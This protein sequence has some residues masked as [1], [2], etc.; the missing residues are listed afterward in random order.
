MNNP[1]GNANDSGGFLPPPPRHTFRDPQASFYAP[2]GTGRAHNNARRGNGGRE[3]PVN[4]DFTTSNPN[5]G[6]GTQHQ[7]RGEVGRTQQYRNYGNGGGRNG[8]GRGGGRNNNRGRGGGRKGGRGN[9]PQGGRTSN[10]YQPLYMQQDGPQGHRTNNPYQ[11][12]QRQPEEAHQNMGNSKDDGTVNFFTTG[13]PHTEPP[14]PKW[15]ILYAAKQ[16][17]NKARGREIPAE[18]E[19]RVLGHDHPIRGRDRRLCYLL[20]G[21]ARMKTFFPYHL[22]FSAMEMVRRLRHLSPEAITDIINDERMENQQELFLERVQAR[23]GKNIDGTLLQESV[24]SLQSMISYEHIHA[25]QTSTSVTETRR[26]HAAILADYSETMFNEAN[27]NHIMTAFQKETVDAQFNIL[28]EAGGIKRLVEA[29]CPSVRL[30]PLDTMPFDIH[31]VSILFP[32]GVEEKIEAQKQRNYEARRNQQNTNTQQ[33][34]DTAGQWPNDKYNHTYQQTAPAGFNYGSQGQ[35]G[36]MS[37]GNALQPSD[38]RDRNQG[39]IEEEEKSRS[40]DDTPADGKEKKIS[41]L[42]TQLGTEISQALDSIYGQHAEAILN[43][44]MKKSMAELS[45]LYEDQAMLERAAEEAL[46]QIN[47][48]GKEPPE[49]EQPTNLQKKDNAVEYEGSSEDPSEEDEEETQSNHGEGAEDMDPDNM[50]NMSQELE[51]AIIAPATTFY[52]KTGLNADQ[53]L[54]LSESELEDKLREVVRTHLVDNYKAEHFEQI[55]HSFMSLTTRQKSDLIFRQGAFSNWVSKMG[56]ISTEERQAKATQRS[57]NCESQQWGTGAHASDQET[58]FD[59][60]LTRY[61]NI[62]IRQKDERAQYIEMAML[63]KGITDG[64][65]HTLRFIPPRMES[66]APQLST[67]SDLPENIGEYICNVATPTATSTMQTMEARVISS[68]DISWLRLENRICP[69]ATHRTGSYFRKHQIRFDVIAREMCSSAPAVAI[70]GTN[71]ID[72]ADQIMSEVRTR[73]LYTSGKEIPA[74]S[75]TIRW[76]TWRS[77]REYSKLEVQ[78]M[79]I[80][81]YWPLRQEMRD[82]FGTLQPN[83]KLKDEFPLTYNMTFFPF[84]PDEGSHFGIEEMDQAIRLQQAHIA[85]RQLII[86][87]GIPKGFDLNYYAR[88]GNDNDVPRSPLAELLHGDRPYSHV[89]EENIG[90]IERIGPLA[91]G[92]YYLQCKRSKADETLALCNNL[93]P[94]LKY[95]CH[96]NLDFHNVSC[97]FFDQCPP[98][99]RTLLARGQQSLAEHLNHPKEAEVTTE[100]TSQRTPGTSSTLTESFVESALIPALKEMHVATEKTITTALKQLSTELAQQIGSKSRPDDLSDQE[101]EFSPSPQHSPQQAG[102]DPPTERTAINEEDH[103][104]RSLYREFENEEG[105]P[106]NEDSLNFSDFPEDLKDMG[107]EH[108]QKLATERREIDA[109]GS[110]DN[111]EPFGRDASRDDRGHSLVDDLARP[112]NLWDDSVNESASASATGGTNENEATP[113]NRKQQAAIVSNRKSE[114]KG[115]AQNRDTRRSKSAPTQNAPGQQDL[116]PKSK[117]AISTPPPKTRAQIRDNSPY[118][119]PGIFAEGK[120][121]LDDF[122]ATD[123]VTNCFNMRLR[124]VYRQLLKGQPQTAAL[125]REVKK[126][127]PK[128]LPHFITEPLHPCFTTEGMIEALSLHSRLAEGGVHMEGEPPISNPRLQHYYNIAMMMIKPNTPPPELKQLLSQID[129]NSPPPILLQ[130]KPSPCTIARLTRLLSEHFS[131]SMA[132]TSLARAAK[133]G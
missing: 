104:A 39:A 67:I 65:G 7:G 27:A 41:S 113:S 20:C 120:G 14:N 117:R 10:P 70:V 64:Y 79:T 88:P 76:R 42:K 81:V 18:G 31:T 11:P 45:Q 123:T 127:N 103:S 22:R 95:V 89:G 78:I 90:L 105:C 34:W 37:R 74:A 48:N 71:S 114:R 119:D 1:S 124:V 115:S 12:L 17:A 57:R 25:L 29:R 122:E 35:T 121:G 102:N 55:F 52:V 61:A 112:A 126:L 97:I 5:P 43:E 107:K 26:N 69:E 80:D 15:Y 109:M 3:G 51:Q 131:T 54:D 44:L 32:E 132:R 40:Q 91:T 130:K 128:Y 77:R 59:I 2:A 28:N 106:A 100:T 16:M 8:N 38:P 118:M 73:A 108:S 101:G 36:D 93:G 92:S 84:Q 21:A 24:L 63:L 9:G 49:G 83:D 85:S 50:F 133:A 33:Q 30:E 23:G 66:I 60:K 47:L 111:R 13:Y 125:K 96:K 98:D 58:T 94:M 6:R 82:V 68:F 56:L 116:P 110:R 46:G 87:Q 99:Y 75:A 53:T 72:D 86:I 62:G 4:L 19:L 129:P